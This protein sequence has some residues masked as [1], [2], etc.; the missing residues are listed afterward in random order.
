MMGMFV[1]YIALLIGISFLSACKHDAALP[2]Y[3]K[4]YKYDGSVQ[5]ERSG[6]ELNVM[7]A[8]LIH[9]GIDVICSQKGHD[10]MN[11]AAVCGGGTGNINIY[12]INRVNLPAAESIR[13]ESVRNLGE[14]Q[15]QK[16]E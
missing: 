16:C 9:A 15:D 5:C 12:K 2:S 3:E 4:V 7:A 14:Y 6:V 8:E 1:K 13:F 10:G 11:R